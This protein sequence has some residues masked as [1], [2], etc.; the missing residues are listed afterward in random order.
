[1]IERRGPVHTGPANFV[2]CNRLP[3]SLRPALRATNRR[4]GQERAE[5]ADHRR[6]RRHPAGQRAAPAGASRPRCSLPGFRSPPAGVG[7]HPAPLVPRKAPTFRRA[8]RSTRSIP[9]SI[10]RR[11]PRPRPICRAPGP[12]PTPPAPG[13]RATSRSPTWKRFPSRI[14]PTRWRRPVPPKPRSPRTT[15]RCEARRSTSASPAS[16][17]RSA[18]RI[19]LSNFTEGALVTAN[20]ADPLTTI[21]RLDPVFVDIQES[22]SDLLALRQ[23]LAKGG[24]ASTTA[25]VRLKLPDGVLL[26]LHRD[27]RIQPGAGAGNYRHRHASRALSPI[28]S[29]CCCRACSSPPNSRK[30]SNLGVPGPQAAVSRDPKGNATL[31]VVGPGNRAVQRTVVA[32]RTQGTDWIVTRPRRGRKGHHAGHRRPSRRGAG[33]TGPGQRPAAPAR[34]LRPT[35]AEACRD[36]FIDRPI[37]AWVIAIIVM[38]VGH[39]RGPRLPVAQYPDVAPPQVNIRAS[40]PGASAE[41]LENSVTQVIEQQLTGHRRPALFQLV[42]DRRAARSASASF[43]KRAPIPTSPRSRSRTRSSRRSAACRCRSSNRACG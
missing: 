5:R 15:R 7:R 24:A 43:S 4:R 31:W 17:R 39:R 38:L 14:I 36:I 23:A 3:T 13:R 32:D 25:Q 42:F 11:R 29:R 40:Y 6:L 30:R 35:K 18:A 34:P 12:A 21:T 8:R 1:M 37:F 27:G 41:T 26:R 33:E 28:P 10:R 19:G 20:Q 2:Y 9:A 16:R 22:A